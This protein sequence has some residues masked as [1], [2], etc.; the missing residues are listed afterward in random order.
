L[1][2]AFR[3][4]LLTNHGRRAAVTVRRNNGYL[5]ISFYNYEGP[6]RRFTRKEL[7]STLNGFVAEIGSKA[8]YGSFDRL[9]ARIQEGLVDDVVAAEQRI[10]S[11][12]RPGVR[13]DLCHSLYFGG[14]KYALI[15]GKAQDRTPFKA[16]GVKWEV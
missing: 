11:Y 5:S 14:I 12:T 16:T 10:T 2:A 4:L 13:L 3:P 9:R 6:P 1:Y 8:E 15:D 7:L